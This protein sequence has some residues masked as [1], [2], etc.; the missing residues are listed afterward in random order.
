MREACSTSY[1]WECMSSHA[2]S[3]IFESAGTSLSPSGRAR[4]Q[5]MPRVLKSCPCL[6]YDALIQRF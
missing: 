4:H 6:V 3:S 2:V 1:R 5:D